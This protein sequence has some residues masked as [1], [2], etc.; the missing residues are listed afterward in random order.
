M[1]LIVDKLCSGRRGIS[2]DGNT[3]RKFFYNSVVSVEITGLNKGLVGC[4][5]TILHTLLSGFHINSDKL[6]EYALIPRE[7][8]FKNIRSTI[9]QLPTTV[10]ELSKQA[11]KSN[12]K[13]YNAFRR[14]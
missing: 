3:S 13:Q 7:F 4:C 9:S 14:D 5:S 10:R 1:G 8:K 6:N 12:N 2:N 11:A